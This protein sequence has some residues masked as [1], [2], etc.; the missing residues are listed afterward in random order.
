MSGEYQRALEFVEQAEATRDLGE[1]RQAL[2]ST[3]D[4]FGVPYFSVV[5][6]LREADGAPTLTPLIRGV[7]DQW[8][9]YYHDQKAFNHDA[10][11]HLALKRPTAFSWSEV[12]SQRLSR[13]SAR[14]FDDIRDLLKIQ[15]GFA[16]P[17]HDEQGF[18]GIVALHHEEPTLTPAAASALKL[19]AIYGMDRARE[20]HD[21]AR[22]AAPRSP[23]PCPLSSRQR[24][25]LSYAAAGKSEPDT[26]DIL[27]ISGAT[28][29]EHMEKVR[30][31]LGVRTKTQA[32]AVAIQRGWIVI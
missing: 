16:I 20:L 28:V 7:T 9:A 22:T 1:L 17:V 12:E 4:Q 10:V 2:T 5:A 29:R 11:V 13:E 3:L 18:A 27:G 32:V 30:D 8:A 19:I 15:G 26:G 24:E 23:A 14:L 25:I 21:L 31:L 6:M